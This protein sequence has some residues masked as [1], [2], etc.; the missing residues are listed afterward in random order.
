[1]IYLNK[2]LPSDSHELFSNERVIILSADFSPEIYSVKISIIF[3]RTVY[4]RDNFKQF[5]IEKSVGNRHQEN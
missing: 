3:D 5:N 1:M 2:I 4:H